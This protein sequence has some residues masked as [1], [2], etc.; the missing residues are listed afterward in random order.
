M[1]ARLADSRRIV[2]WRVILGPEAPLPELSAG[3][4]PA[5]LG[6]LLAAIDELA[7][8]DDTDLV[9]KRAVE[10]TRERIGLTRTGIFLL[11]PS[12]ARMFGTWGT[13]LKGETTDEHHLVF[14]VRE[15]DRAAQQR[16]GDGAGHWLMFEN[17][18]LVELLENEA[19]VIGR[20]WV[21]CTPLRSARRQIGM[22]FNDPGLSGA[23][24]DETKQVQLAVF[25]SLLATLLDV[26]AVSG[27]RRSALHPI[28]SKAVQLLA[29]DPSAGGEALARHVGLSLSR[30]ARVFKA[31]MGMSLVEY[32]NRLR[33]ER[34]FVLV[35]ARGSN[36]L[37]A[38]LAS[39]F[40]SYA[41]FHR[42]FRALK[43]QAPRDYLRGKS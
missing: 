4:P 12:G 28:V 19:R 36:L 9:L 41:Q 11:D 34:F 40:G 20:S 6:P 10:L 31:E 27:A 25:C 14:S 18:P 15:D 2:D 42:V 39:G 43:G 29:R 8:L 22:M 7:G 13:S 17:C 24:L 3:K 26:T 23:P 21:A 33:L 38:A 35:D 5:G 32:R 16:A 1:D 30:L 37:Q